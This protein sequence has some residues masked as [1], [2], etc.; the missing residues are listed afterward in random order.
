M[1]KSKKELPLVPRDSDNNFRMLN[2]DVAGFMANQLSLKDLLSLISSS[3]TTYNLFKPNLIRVLG[4]K[5]KDCVILG[6][7]DGLMAIVKNKPDALFDISPITD[8]RERIFYASF[9]PINSFY[10]TVI[11]T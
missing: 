1:S 10:F 11:K 2:N 4:I 6:D 8:L 5:A 3:I 9:Q 7:V